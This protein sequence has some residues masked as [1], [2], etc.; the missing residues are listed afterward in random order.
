MRRQSPEC[1]KI[2]AKYIFEKRLI[3]KLYKELL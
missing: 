1:E 3:S 2:F